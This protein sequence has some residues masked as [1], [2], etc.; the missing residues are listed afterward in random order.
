LKL[1]P[2]LAKEKKETVEKLIAQA[3]QSK[4]VQ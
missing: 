4:L 2:T 1:N 3:Q